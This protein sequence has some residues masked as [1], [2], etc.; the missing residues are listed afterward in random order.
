MAINV[1]LVTVD[2]LLVTDECVTGS[3]DTI[4]IHR[5][6]LTHQ[7]S[8]GTAAVTANNVT[9]GM[10]IMCGW[11]ADD[12]FLA[13]VQISLSGS[14]TTTPIGTERTV[15]VHGMSL[16]T[17]D[18]I[19][20][21]IGRLT[22]AGTNALKSITRV[23]NGGSSHSVRPH[24]SEAEELLVSVRVNG[25]GTAADF[26]EVV[27]DGLTAKGN[28]V[29]TIVND[30]PDTTVIAPTVITTRLGRSVVHSVTTE[31]NRST[32]L[33]RGTTAR[34]HIR[35]TVA[36][37]CTANRIS[38]NRINFEIFE[39]RVNTIDMCA[40]TVKDT[41]AYG[42]TANRI[43][44]NAFTILSTGF[45]TYTLT[46][47]NYATGMTATRVSNEAFLNVGRAIGASVFLLHGRTALRVR[48]AAL[49]INYVRV[50]RFR[51]IVVRIIF[52]DAYRS[53]A[54]SAHFVFVR[55]LND[56][57]ITHLGEQS[58]CVVNR[59]NE[60]VKDIMS[61]KDEI[62]VFTRQ[63]VLTGRFITDQGV[64]YDLLVVLSNWH[65]AFDSIRRELVFVQ[66]LG[67]VTI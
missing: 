50:G 37:S 2:V 63:V 30:G 29:N 49:I 20:R 52:I 45:S 7:T 11:S 1:L 13:H 35:Y 24:R 59:V 48:H 27:T 36:K 67:L 6:H 43:R 55:D 33:N 32:T 53:N 26:F 21:H 17:H 25:M 42:R 41:I 8:Y 56:A 10:Q 12:V 22:R 31:G 39:M 15:I 40:T 58:D 14:T 51:M 5:R 46:V 3:Y 18:S 54:T 9:T 65:Y 47:E 4:D 62:A 44:D 34:S 28:S 60:S 57:N 23:E 38:F 16:T 61:R 64:R 19:G 66:V